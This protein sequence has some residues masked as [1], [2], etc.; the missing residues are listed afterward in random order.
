ME[1]SKVTKDLATILLFSTVVNGYVVSKFAPRIGSAL[2]LGSY[3]G[4]GIVSLIGIP[5]IIKEGMSN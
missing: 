5:F 1:A 3:F 2:T 4:A